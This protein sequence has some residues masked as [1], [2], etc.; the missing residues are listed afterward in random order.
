MHLDRKV[1]SKNSA[2]AQSGPFSHLLTYRYF[3]GYQFENL[4]KKHH[5][6]VYY[7]KWYI[8]MTV[9]TSF[10]HSS[11]WPSLQLQIIFT[12]WQYANTSGAMYRYSKSSPNNGKFLVWRVNWGMLTKTTVIQQLW[13]IAYDDLLLWWQT[14][15]K[16]PMDLPL[17]SVLDQCAMCVVSHSQTH[18]SLSTQFLCYSSLRSMH[19]WLCV[20]SCACI[21]AYYVF[22][23][24]PQSPTFC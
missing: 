17:Q 18:F 6:F 4:S 7:V 21:S 11:P 22:R 14:P 8:V 13:D 23:L 24:F 1:K 5:L 15:V 3:K 9:T 16:P 2:S 19:C 12:V 10:I 20:V